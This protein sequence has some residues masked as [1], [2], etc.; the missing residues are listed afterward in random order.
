MDRDV[1][2]IMLLQQDLNTIAKYCQVNK[3]A[4]KFGENDYFW[5]QLVQKHFN[6]QTK[7]LSTW[8]HT[9]EFLNKDIYHVIDNTNQKNKSFTNYNNALNYA[10]ERAMYY[11]PSI[12]NS[13]PLDLSKFNFSDEF[14]DLVHE[15]GFEDLSGNVEDDQKLMDD[16]KLYVSEHEKLL[17]SVLIDQNIL[18]FDC[19]TICRVEIV[20]MKIRP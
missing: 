16:Y 18:E 3:E 1:A 15:L 11:T 10:I 2:K 5:K 13:Q 9:Y 4:A 14:L 20:K 7:I 12:L 17:K 8:K 6:T 19:D